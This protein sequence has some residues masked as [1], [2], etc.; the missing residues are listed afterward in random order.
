MEIEKE[1][2]VDLEAGSYGKELDVEEKEEEKEEKEE[3]EEKKE[4][5]RRN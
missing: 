1:F 4:R 2:L 5:K 3:E